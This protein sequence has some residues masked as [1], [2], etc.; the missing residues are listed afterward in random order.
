MEESEK[1]IQQK[2]KFI[3]KPIIQCIPI[4]NEKQIIISWQIKYLLFT[5]KE[6]ITRLNTQFKT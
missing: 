6:E 1:Y 5:P 2:K 4:K 3:I